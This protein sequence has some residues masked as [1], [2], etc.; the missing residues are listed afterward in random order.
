MFAIVSTRE[1]VEF[2]HKLTSLLGGVAATT[3]CMET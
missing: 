3:V 1:S 2:I